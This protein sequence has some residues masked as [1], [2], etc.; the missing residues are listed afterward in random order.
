MFQLILF[1]G[2]GRILG[3]LREGWCTKPC[4]FRFTF[5]LFGSGQQF[6]LLCCSGSSFTCCPAAVSWVAAQKVSEC[7]EFCDH[8]PVE[9]IGE[10]VP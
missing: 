10:T 8:R 1:V 5:A 7:H 6:R 4:F 3:C 9:A 2:A